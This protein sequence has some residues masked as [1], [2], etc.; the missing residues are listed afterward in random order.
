MQ[1]DDALDQRLTAADASGQVLR[2][3]GSY[4]AGSGACEVALKAYARSHPFA[5][6]AGTDNIVAFTTER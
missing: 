3:V 2:Y 6:L 5:Q 4:D 1:F